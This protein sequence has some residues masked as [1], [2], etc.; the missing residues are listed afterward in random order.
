MI[1]YDM[2]WYDMIW[3]FLLKNFIILIYFTIYI[4]TTIQ[5]IFHL[6]IQFIIYFIFYFI[7]PINNNQLEF[8]FLHEYIL[9][10]LPQYHNNHQYKK[11]SNKISLWKKTYKYTMNM[12]H[13]QHSLSKCLTH[14]S[15]TFYMALRNVT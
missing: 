5:I 8:V 1:W 12:L 4:N 3:E 9:N 13:N 10:K 2:I 15:H 6:F 11:E 14:H 7:L